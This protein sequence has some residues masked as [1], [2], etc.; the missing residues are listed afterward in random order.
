[1]A[2]DE[3]DL[4]DLEGFGETTPEDD[5]IVERKGDIDESLRKIAVACK[6]V[7]KSRRQEQLIHI[8]MQ[9]GLLNPLAP[10]G[11]AYVG[12][13]GLSWTIAVQTFAA[14][15]AFRKTMDEFVAAIQRCGFAQVERTLKGLERPQ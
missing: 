9:P 4:E 7:S 3:M 1:M 13:R 11:P 8:R 12:W 5:V 6:R 15:Q 10:Q 14:G 2:G